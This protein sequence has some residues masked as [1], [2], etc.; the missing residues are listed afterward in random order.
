MPKPTP[1]ENE[2]QFISRCMG[3]NTMNNDYPDTAQRVAI[4][5]VIWGEQ[6]KTKKQDGNQGNN[7]G[8]K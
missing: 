5:Y 2:R 6:K 7:H 3:D 4:C 8:L 1:Q